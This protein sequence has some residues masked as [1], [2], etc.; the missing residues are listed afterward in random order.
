MQAVNNRERQVLAELDRQDLAGLLRELVRRPS[1]ATEGEVVAYLDQ[2]WRGRGLETT[3]SEARPGRSNVTASTGSA[4]PA[5]LFNSHMDTVPLGERGRWSV[6][7]LG[8][9]VK[10]GRL[11]GRGAVDAKGCLAAMIGAFEAMATVGVPGRVIMS[12]VAYEENGG[13]GTRHDVERGLR[14]DAAIIG[15]PTNL[16]PNLGHRGA[17]RLEVESIGAPAH[18]AH[19]EEGINA[20]TGVAPVVLAIDALNAR[21][22]SR[23]DPILQ[24][25]PN[26]TVTMIQGGDAGNVVPA[27]CTLIIDRRTLP[28]ESAEQVVDEV[29]AAIEEAARGGQATIRLQTVRQVSPAVTAPDAPIARALCDAIAAGSGRPPRAAGF[30]ACCDMTYLSAVGIPTVIFGPGEE[31]MCHVFDESLAVADLQ[32]AAQ[33]YALTA[34]RWFAEQG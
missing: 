24:Q 1:Y 19:P 29:N 4:G 10:D 22:A 15:E 9:V 3:V 5:L 32:R 2:R 16:Q 11:Y 27:R 8:G 30:F 26:I 33:V 25:H 34:L 17:C 31:S 6:D 21:L 23:I 13:Y 20:I 18:S 7:P 14:A 12:A 28:S